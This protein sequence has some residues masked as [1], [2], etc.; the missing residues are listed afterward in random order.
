MEILIRKIRRADA[1]AIAS[2]SQQ[3]G[4]KASEKETAERITSIENNPEHLLS[5]VEVSNQ[6]V[7]WIHAFV[8]LHLESNSFVEI[9]GL[10]VDENYRKQGIG[11]KLIAEVEK[12]AIEKKLNHLR[13]RSN[14][15]RKETHQFYLNRRFQLT[16]EQK[17]FD[18]RI[19]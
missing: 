2:L 9:G 5:L 15:I 7:G 18:K 4:Y 19:S 1:A 12:W 13:V 17:I 6:I 16:K 3:L 14:I 8:S 10:V 11:Q